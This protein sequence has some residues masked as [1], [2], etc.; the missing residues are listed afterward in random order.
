MDPNN[1]PTTCLRIGKAKLLGVVP[2]G[3][4]LTLIHTAFKGPCNKHR[5][6]LKATSHQIVLRQDDRP[7]HEEPAYLHFAAGDEFYFHDR[8]FSVLNKDGLSVTYMFGH[9]TPGDRPANVGEKAAV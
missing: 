1:L 6:V 4:Q 8:G 2:P 7:D 5:T 3:T 9:V